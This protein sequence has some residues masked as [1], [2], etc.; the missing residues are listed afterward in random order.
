MHKYV[1]KPKICKFVQKIPKNAKLCNKNFFVFEIY[2]VH[3]VPR[4][5]FVSNQNFNMH[6]LD[7]YAK[8]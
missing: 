8:A 4:I 6:F 7:K 3:Y 2:V 5:E 1:L